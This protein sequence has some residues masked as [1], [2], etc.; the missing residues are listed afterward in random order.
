M[1]NEFTDPNIADSP[2]PVGYTDTNKA[3][4]ITQLRDEAR[5]TSLWLPMLDERPTKSKV[6]ERGSWPSTHTVLNLSSGAGVVRSFWSTCT[7]DHV[8]RVFVNGE[9]TPRIEAPLSAL[10]GYATH[11][12]Q[13]YGKWFGGNNSYYEDGEGYATNTHTSFFR[14]P[15]PFHNGIRIEL[16]GGDPFAYYQLNYT[17][18]DDIDY[19]RYNHLNAFYSKALGPTDLPQSPNA[20]RASRL[21]RVEGTRG[22][23]FAMLQRQRGITGPWE[24]NIDYAIDFPNADPYPAG[25]ASPNSHTNQ[26]IISTSG[27]EDYYFG[28]YYWDAFFT[29]STPFTTW[30][31]PHV[32]VVYAVPIVGQPDQK[33]IACFRIHDDNPYCFESKMDAY[34]HED[35]NWARFTYLESLVLVYTET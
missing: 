2:A 7:N 33:D 18:G 3:E 30:A 25:A 32:G 23:V 16:L 14:F 35:P 13:F 22:A 1:R 20:A 5:K 11:H 21:A 10:G 8:M 31:S 24:T 6:M 29:R 34:F 27:W 15:I 26:N 12:G 9:A 28:S 17:L 19:G 4:H